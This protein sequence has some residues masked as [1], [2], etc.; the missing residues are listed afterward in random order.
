MPLQN[1][2]KK[3]GVGIFKPYN[4]ER[5]C[6]T[7][8]DQNQSLQNRLNSVQ[9]REQQISSQC[10]NLY[11]DNCRLQGRLTAELAWKQG[12]SANLKQ[13]EET[14]VD[15]E[16]QYDGLK[17][18]YDKKVQSYKELDKNYMD[19]VRPLRVSDDDHSTIYR[20]LMHIRVSIESLVQKAR[21]EGSVNLNKQEAIDYFRE[22][23]LLED[24]P[25]EEAILDPYHLNLCAESAIMTTLIVRFFNRPLACIFRH[26]K[27]YKKISRWV[28]KRDSKIAV[29]WRQQLCILIAHDP[30]GM[31]RKREREVNEAATALSSLVSRVYP[32][33]DMS[34]KIK[35][36]CYNSFNLS[37][38]MFG[39]ESVIY[40]VWTPPGTPFD[41]TTMTTPQK[42]NP[43]GTVSLL[44]YSSTCYDTQHQDSFISKL[45]GTNRQYLPEVA[46]QNM[47]NWRINPS[48]GQEADK[49]V[50]QNGTDITNL[51]FELSTDL[52]EVRLGNVRL[53]LSA[54]EY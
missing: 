48:P 44:L 10:R 13:L 16:R 22:F 53:F 21:G 34:I 7:L 1:F 30:K 2:Y 25:V 17:R 26:S 9:T 42:S 32:N 31:E 27:E 43:T 6:R 50:V 40:P 47:K 4:A 51:Y 19:L 35:E 14:N 38:D 36:L 33:L 54:R 52:Y 3:M 46:N 39:M 49:D 18:R 23:Q 28:E 29:R 11:Q 12:M 5:R 41:D 15:L 20:R 24:F 37:F 45:T 8:F